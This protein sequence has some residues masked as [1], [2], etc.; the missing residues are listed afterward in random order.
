MVATKVEEC[1][2]K[3]HIEIG[4]T[5]NR[6]D[7]MSHI[8]VAKEVCAYLSH[9]YKKIV[10]V[11][12]PFQK[13]NFKVDSNTLPF[14]VIIENTEAC[15]RYT[16]LGITN[17]KVDTSPTWLQQRLKSVGVRPILK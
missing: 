7:A 11:R 4:L 13:D 8:G 15:E 10:S 14:T 9:Y 1:R 2:S 5:P 12:P 3:T 17:V 6:I 16:G